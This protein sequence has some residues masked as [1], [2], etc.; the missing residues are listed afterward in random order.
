MAKLFIGIAAAF[1]LATAVVSF[2][3]KGKVDALQADRKSAN[4]R[5][6]GAEGQ[7]KA[8]KK[9]ADDA[10]KDAKE[11]AGKLEDA[12]KEVAQ[13]TKDADDAKKQ[14]DEAK[15]LND[16]KDKKIADLTE[17]LK[18]A[19]GGITQEKFAEV[20][21]Q[22]Q[23]MTTQKD[24]AVKEAAEKQAVIDSQSAKVKA[25][26]E[27]VAKYELIERKRNLK[28]GLSGL[29]AR[30]LAVNAGWNFVVL[31]KGDRAGVTLDDPLIV[32]RG[33]EPVARLR[34][35][36][37]EPSTSIAD[38]LPSSVRRGISVQPGDTV[39]FQGRTA[40]TLPENKPAPEAP[41]GAITP[42]AAPPN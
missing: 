8:A 7:A 27:K 31:D 39:I 29:R 40:A 18:N 15:L 2:L 6:S 22:L 14:L 35:T 28:E 36:S 20:Q 19:P 34:V 4:L 26:D 25:D 41:A 24:T 9:E 32:V 37:V 38:V 3:L 1:M 30:I 5:I 33:N 42:P 17:K 12:T 23:D 11:A 10:K 13:K 16:E 21:A